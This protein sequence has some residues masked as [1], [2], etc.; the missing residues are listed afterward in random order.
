MSIYHIQNMSIT[1]SGYTGIA[2]LPNFA[3]S[4]QKAFICT[5]QLPY[6]QISNAKMVAILL[7]LDLC[8]PPSISIYKSL[9]RSLHPL[10]PIHP[11]LHLDPL[12]YLHPFSSLRPQFWHFP[13]HFQSRC[14]H[15]LPPHFLCEYLHFSTQITSYNFKNAALNTVCY[16]ATIMFLYTV[17]IYYI[18]ALIRLNIFLLP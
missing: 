8:V 10:L 7:Q 1:Q 15:F 3:A 17:Y 5:V 14:L 6:L 11:L 9:T 12:F 16:I 13:P 18:A 4:Q 2:S